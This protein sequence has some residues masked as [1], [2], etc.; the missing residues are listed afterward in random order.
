MDKASLGDVELEYETRGSGEAVVL[1]H[2]GAGLAGS[3]HC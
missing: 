2:H 3:G 1:V